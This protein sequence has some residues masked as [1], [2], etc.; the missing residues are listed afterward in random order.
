[1]SGT[2]INGLFIKGI[3]PFKIPFILDDWFQLKIKLSKQ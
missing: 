3:L 1:M 2:D